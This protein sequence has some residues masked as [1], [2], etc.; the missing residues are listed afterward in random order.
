MGFCLFNNVA[1]A[2][3][4]AQQQHRLARILIV[5]WD[6]HHGNGTQAIFDDDPDRDVLLGP[7]APVLSRHGP[8][9]RHGAGQGA[10]HEDQRAAAG[11]IGRCASTSRRS[12]S[13]CGRPPLAFRPDLVLISAGFDAHED[14]LLG[15]MKVSTEGYAELT[16]RVR[17]IADECCQGR[18][19]SRARRRLQSGG[20]GSLG[21]S[22]RA[23]ADGTS[24]VHPAGVG[25][26]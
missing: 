6:V 8:G 9:G 14:D 7:P 4:Y 17:R 23:G 1:I 2:A 5:D 26:S 12:T 21:R 10:G 16:R 18:L 15:G 19:I 20:I 25:R 13:S 11:R 24:R 3:R 22:P